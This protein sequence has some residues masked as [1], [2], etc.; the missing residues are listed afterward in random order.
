MIGESY[1]AGEGSLAP[2]DC[3]SRALG[4]LE[5]TFGLWIYD[6]NFN[7]TYIAR[8]GSTVFVN[9][10]YNE[11]SSVKFPNSEAL[12]EGVLYQLTPEGITAVA[13]FDF[14]SPFFT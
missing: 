14:N 10:L 3:I 8:C 11:F 6:S 12:P 4:L 9:L 7:T 5:G 1:K 2:A 13:R